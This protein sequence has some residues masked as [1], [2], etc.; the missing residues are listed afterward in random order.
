MNVVIPMAG[1]GS[2]FAR[3]GITTPKPLILVAGRPMIAWAIE[4]VR[5]I[6]A[7]RWIFVAL[8]EHEERYGVTTILHSLGDAC[9]VEVILLDDVTEGQLCTILAAREWID[10]D[11][12]IL[13]ASADTYVVS[14]LARDIANRSSACRGIISVANMPGDRWSF[15]RTDASGRVIEVAEKVRISDYASTGLYYFTNGREFLSAADEIISNQEKTQGEYYVI[16]VY[17][18]YIQR[19]CW[20]GISAAEA[21]WDMG[22]PD[23]LQAFERF[24]SG[25]QT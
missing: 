5:H 1:R 16:P 25:A 8:K 20:V 15:A 23:A 6:P 19:S 12:D 9:P 10:T 4:S 2:R 7:S 24:L 3:H 18:K 22:T 21:M 17:K 11:E 14:N 13:I